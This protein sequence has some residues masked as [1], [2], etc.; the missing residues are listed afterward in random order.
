M[1]ITLG[2][3]DLFSYL[4]PGILYLFVINQFFF[5]LGRKAIDVMSWFQPG[6][7]I[8]FTVVIPILVGAF[9]IG[10]LFDILSYRFFGFFYRFRKRPKLSEQSLFSIKQRYPDM[11]IKFNANDWSTLFVFVRL[12]NLEL[13]Q[14]IDK[15]NAD[16]IMFRNFSFGFFLLSVVCVI[17]F[18]KTGNWAFLISA[19]LAFFFFLIAHT[20]SNG[21]RIRFFKQIF[22]ASLAYGKSIS[23]VVEYDGREKRTS[24]KKTKKIPSK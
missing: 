7:S 9:I 21:L 14:L 12:R 15:F 22:R 1:S 23:E 8:G 17:D 16:S 10:Y 19:V 5:V 24:I 13:S 11:K 6:Q 2:I 20:R 18:F 4:T 3:Y